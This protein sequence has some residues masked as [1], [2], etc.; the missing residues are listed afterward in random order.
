MKSF[1]FPHD[2]NARN[3]PKIVKMRLKAPS[4]GISGAEAVGYY[5]MTVEMLDEQEDAR[6]SLD[7]E[8]LM[9]CAWQCGAIEATNSVTNGST[10][11]ATNSV[12]KYTTKCARYVQWLKMCIEIGLFSA[13]EKHFWSES[14]LRRRKVRK[15]RASA[16]RKSAK[17]KKHN[18]LAGQQNAQQNTQQNTQQNGQQNT[19]QNLAIKENKIKGNKVGT[20]T[21][22]ST[23]IDISTTNICTAENKV[24]K[25]E[26]IRRFEETWKIYPNRQGKKQALRHYL[27][28]VKTD[29]DSRRCWQALQ[30]YLKS[31]KVRNGFVKNGSTFF[32]DWESWVEPTPQMMGNHVQEAESTYG[33]QRR[34]E[35]CGDTYWSKLGHPES[36]CEIRRR[37]IAAS[38]QPTLENSTVDRNGAQSLIDASG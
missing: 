27:A 35:L 34:C 37:A 14:L 29:D 24:S 18:N 16:G 3:D 13:S 17:L 28:T 7:E 31:E 32:N 9:G 6:L 30:N 5:W 36:L 20:N 2:D 26:L 1:Y 33:V 23:T 12:T 11:G 21:G 10:N 19:Q 4:L 38:S 8:T 15:L 25:A 22:T